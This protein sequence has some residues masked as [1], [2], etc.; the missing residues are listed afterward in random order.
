MSRKSYTGKEVSVS[1]PYSHA[2]DAGSHLFFSGQ[3]AR[4]ALDYEEVTGSIEEQTKQCFINLERVMKDAGVTF[5]DVVKAN[6][7]LT[8]MKNFQG[9][10]G[11]Y[12]TMFSEPYPARTCVAVYELPLGA[13]VEIEVVVY[14]KIK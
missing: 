10:N 9:M 3:V 11:V 5:D 7:Y 14:K 12:E 4:N 13:D 1:G 6:V 8:S 2:I